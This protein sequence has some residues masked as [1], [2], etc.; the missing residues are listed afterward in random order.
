M[1]AATDG[2]DPDDLPVVVDLLG[3]VAGGGVLGG[4]LEAD[5][6]VWG[7]RSWFVD[8]FELAEAGV[9]EAVVVAEEIQEPMAAVARGTP[10]GAVAVDALL[11]RVVGG[12]V[13]VVTDVCL[14]GCGC[15]RRHS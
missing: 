13:G 8:G 15:G 6:A 3:D 7:G 2:A 11:D 5:G 14:L 12:A 10:L 1:A 9:A 4:V